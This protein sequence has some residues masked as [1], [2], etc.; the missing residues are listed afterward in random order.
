MAIDYQ[1]EDVQNGL[2]ATQRINAEL[3]RIRV[4]LREAVSRVGTSPNFMEAD[5][6]MN[7]YDI[8]NVNMIDV[9]EIIMNG[10]RIPTLDELLALRDQLEQMLIDMND[11]AAR[12][13]HSAS[14]AGAAATSAT[15]SANQASQ[16][17]ATAAQAA[18]DAVEAAQLIIDEL[19]ILLPKFIYTET[20]TLRPEDYKRK[21]IIDGRC[22][23]T[24]PAAPKMPWY[25]EIMR[26]SLHEVTFE[27]DT[28][29]YSTP[30]QSN[31]I[32]RPH[33]WAGVYYQAVDHPCLM[34]DVEYVEPIAPTN[35]VLVAVERNL[36]P[37]VSSGVHKTDALDWVPSE[38]SPA[39]INLLPGGTQYT[40]SEL[41]TA[42]DAVR[43][44][45]T[46]GPSVGATI[47]FTGAGDLANLVTSEY[48]D[49]PLY[50]VEDYN[51][52]TIKSQ[53]DTLDAAVD[54]ADIGDWIMCYPMCLTIVGRSPISGPTP[55]VGSK[56]REV[57]VEV[58][59][60]PAG[61][62]LGWYSVPGNYVEVTE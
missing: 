24:I 49:E 29:Y 30:E 45:M 61:V 2:F 6:D 40:V 59:D 7:L 55:P 41:Q 32:R 39:T 12:A 31:A 46:G 58:M 44:S 34:G 22:H 48:T 47:G 57:H 54:A 10:E 38:P 23:I 19:Q 8:L 21:L 1:R 20:Y 28:T 17:A 26:G 27:F 25:V 56:S 37:T 62:V 9:K 42:L 60:H 51:T 50:V 5:L 16:D 53:H 35:K 4:L 14:I 3:E 18:I 15:N 11:A 52:G 33:S 43:G 13:A 36:G